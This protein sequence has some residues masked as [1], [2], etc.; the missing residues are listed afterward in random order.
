[1][2]KRNNGE[3]ELQG[4][5]DLRQHEQPPGSLFAQVNYGHDGRDDRQKSRGHAAYPRGYAEIE[6]TLHDY[7]P[8]QSAG[9][10]RTLSGCKKRDCEGNRGKCRPQDWG[11]EFVGVLNLGHP[12]KAMPVKRRGGHDQDRGVDNEGHV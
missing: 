5:H 6:K 2:D 11:Q 12:E 1:M 7:L 9:N 3:R 4:E 8:G 10:G